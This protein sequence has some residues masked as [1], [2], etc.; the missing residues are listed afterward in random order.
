MSVAA[1]IL[2]YLAVIG[3]SCF[4]LRHLVGTSRAG[5]SGGCFAGGL[6]AG[7]GCKVILTCLVCILPVLLLYSL[8]VGIGYDYA[9]YEK[10][11]HVLHHVSFFQYWTL[12]LK[13]GAHFYAEPGYYL[14]NRLAPNYHMLLLLDVLVITV[15]FFKAIYTY[16]KD[17]PLYFSFFIHYSLQF[18]Y[19]MNGV[20]YIM[21]LS[22]VLLAFVYLLHDK[23]LKFLICVVVAAMFHTTAWLVLLYLLVREFQSKLLNRVRDLAL[24]TGTLLVPYAGEIFYLLG[25]SVPVFRRLCAVYPVSKELTL[26]FTF[27][28]HFVPVLFPVLFVLGKTM[29]ESREERTMFRICITEIPLRIFSFYN[30]WFFRLCRIPQLMQVIFIPCML[31]KVRRSQ[32]R[33]LLMIYYIV[34]YI[35]YFLYY[36]LGTDQVSIHY[37]WIFG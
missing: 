25:S 11:Y 32:D 10:T 17:L 18:I 14:L 6:G 5:I 34:W 4:F 23:T 16:R 8:R 21:A 19:S 35:F 22:F 31:K 1:S 28:L 26:S 30:H 20:R 27:W 13:G 36:L 24:I 12:H 2:L 33:K 15:P 9:A 7:N 29:F 3:I 37:Q